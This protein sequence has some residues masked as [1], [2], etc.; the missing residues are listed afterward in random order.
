[1]LRHIYTTMKVKL[2]DSSPVVV[3][4]KQCSCV[5]GTVVCSHTVAL[6]FQTAHYSQLKIPVVPHVHSC[7]E[8]EQQWHKLRTMGVRPGP[9]KSM[10][11]TKPVPNRMV[12]T[13]VRSGCYRGMVVPL[14]EPCMFRIEEAYAK[15]SIEDRPLV[16]TMNMGPDKPLVESA[17]GLVQRGSILSYQKP[18]LTSRYITL[19]H[20]VPPTPHLP[21]EDYNILPSDC[22][23]VCS[24]EELLHLSSLTMEMAHKIEEATREQSSCSE[25]YLLR[26]PRV[27]ASRF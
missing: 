8:S 24:E 19:H 2:R 25:W 11:F 4:H 22:V 3:T 7:T 13:G 15:F 20:D 12:Q 23:F 21:L 9:I 18:A 1:M 10:V 14:P 27:T 5:A 6:L 16:T 17:F 26:R